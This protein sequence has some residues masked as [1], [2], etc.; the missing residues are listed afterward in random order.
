MTLCFEK[1]VITKQPP[2]KKKRK[3]KKVIVGV[4]GTGRQEQVAEIKKKWGL[5][6]TAGVGSLVAWHPKG[7]LS[8]KIGTFA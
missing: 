2:P 6:Y 8:I 5:K 7:K 4:S 1:K 3:K